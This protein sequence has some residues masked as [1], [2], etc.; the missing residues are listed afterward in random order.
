MHNPSACV[1]SKETQLLSNFNC[2]FYQ[3]KLNNKFVSRILYPLWLNKRLKIILFLSNFIDIYFMIFYTWELFFIIIGLTFN[4]GAI[5]GWCAVNN[6]IDMG[7]VL[8]LYLS[9]IMWTLAY[10]T[11]YAHQVLLFDLNASWH[12]YLPDMSTVT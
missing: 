3:T 6:S 12:S 9:C 1:G 10:D 8:P 4:W 7:V 2:S 5:L 11:I